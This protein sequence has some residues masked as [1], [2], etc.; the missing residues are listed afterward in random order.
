MKKIALYYR[1]FNNISNPSDSCMK[2]VRGIIILYIVYFL[3]QTAE[4]KPY[5]YAYWSSV[6]V[7]QI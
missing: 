7:K 2:T 5:G 6:P 4:D 1:N 3:V